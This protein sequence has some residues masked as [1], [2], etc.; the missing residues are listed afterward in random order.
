MELRPSSVS[1]S[2]VRAFKWAVAIGIAAWFVGVQPMSAQISRVGAVTSVF[3]SRAAN[4]SPM[5]GSDSAY[6]PVNKVF[7]VVATCYNSG[8]CPVG[9]GNVFGIFVNNTGAAVGGAFAISS[10]D[11]HFP[12][13]RYS[14]DVNGGQGGFLVVWSREGGGGANLIQTR[15]VVYDPSNNSG[16]LVGVENTINGIAGNFGSSLSFA[17]LEGAV[18]VAYSPTSQRFLLAWRT[19][20]H[21]PLGGYPSSGSALPCR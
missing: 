8:T 6:D 12:R 10:G 13:A 21:A 5:K 19:Y 7:L 1:F 4:T 11:S 16:T 14:R 9:L 17:W 20:P 2:L 15:V 18:S 3:A